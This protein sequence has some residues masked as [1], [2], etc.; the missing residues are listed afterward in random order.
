MADSRWRSG[1][2]FVPV[3]GGGFGPGQIPPRTGGASMPTVTSGGLSNGYQA[4]PP[5]PAPWDNAPAGGD[6]SFIKKAL[7]WA[8]DHPEI[9]LGG[10]GAIQGARQ[11]GR[12]N[13]FREEAVG[14]ARDRD[15]ARQPYRD[16]LQ[17]RLLAPVA[18]APDFSTQFA[19]SGNSYNKIRPRPGMLQQA[20][21]P[22]MP[23]GS[24]TGERMQNASQQ[25]GASPLLSRLQR[26]L[27]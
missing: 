14:I 27:R 19:D 7:K 26:A 12:A 17:G 6:D 9:I 18:S 10:V 5:V 23:T 21:G 11:Q 25:P 4:G 3:S 20:L 24:N 8:L 13:D 22:Q 1:A 16:A 2:P 15:A